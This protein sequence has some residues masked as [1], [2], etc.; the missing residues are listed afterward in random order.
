MS[1]RVTLTSV[2]EIAGSTIAGNG[3]QR[4]YLSANGLGGPDVAGYNVP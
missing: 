1:R 2:R 4:V 3:F